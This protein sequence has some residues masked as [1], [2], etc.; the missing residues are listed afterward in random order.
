MASTF[1]QFLFNING[2]GHDVNYPQDFR[3]TVDADLEVRGTRKVQF[4][5]GD[6][7]VR[8]AE[9]TH[10]IE[11][12]ELINQRPQQTLE[13]GSESHPS[14]RPRISTSCGSKDGTR[15]SCGTTLATC[16]ASLSLQLDGPVKDPIIEGRITATRGTLNFR[17]H[18]L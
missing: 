12:A 18:S 5:S 14:P 1:R 10:D 2:T 3:S 4:I 16:V 7:R 6:V 15:D 13:E 11:L 17:Q 9:Y 8:R